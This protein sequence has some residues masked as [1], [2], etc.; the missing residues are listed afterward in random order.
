M[1]G[2]FL[3]EFTEHLVTLL[4]NKQNNIIIGDFNM[5]LDD[6]HDPD[7]MI[8][9]DTITAFGLRLHI[10]IATNNKGNTLDLL[11]SEDQANLI[12]KVEHGA[13]ISDHLRSLPPECCT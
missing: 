6:P 5:H 1:N 9:N 3:D 7:V 2:M 10:N 4:T 12:E 11:L 13:M 8:F